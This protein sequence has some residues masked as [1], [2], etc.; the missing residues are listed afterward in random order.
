MIICG[1]DIKPVMQKLQLLHHYGEW[2]TWF[3]GFDNSITDAIPECTELRARALMKVLGKIGFVDGCHCGCR[4]D[5]EI[6]QAGGLWLHDQHMEELRSRQ[7][8]K[9]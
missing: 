1:I 8:T 9:K 2:G 5:Y 7:E 3:S 6:T 4:G